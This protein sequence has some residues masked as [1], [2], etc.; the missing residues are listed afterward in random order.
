MRFFFLLLAS[1][2]EGIAEAPQHR[3][4]FRSARARVLR[5]SRGAVVIAHATNER[6][7]TLYSVVRAITI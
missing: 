1:R 2:V 5:L 7:T 3:Y 6:D 4:I